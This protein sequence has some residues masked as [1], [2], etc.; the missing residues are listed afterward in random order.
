MK[1]SIYRTQKSAD[2]FLQ[3][4]DQVNTRK[5]MVYA[6]PAMQKKNDTEYCLINLHPDV[7]FQKVE[8][9]GGAIT[10]AAACA[11]SQLGEENRKK[12]VKMYFDPEEGIGYT[13][14]R[15]CMGSSD[16]AIDEYTYVE[17]GDMDLH[18]FD[19]SREDKYVVPLVKEAQ[20]LAPQLRFFFAP[21][22]PPLYMKDTD[23][24]QGG[25][26]KEECY[27]LYAQY[28]KK[29]ILEMKKRGIDI[30]LATVQNETRHM[31]T[32]ESCCYS[33]EQEKK[34]I[35]DHLGPVLDELGIKIM[36]Y[37]HCKER[38]FERCKAMYEDPETAK[39]IYGIACHWY[40]GDH[41]GE[42]S[43]AR[44]KYPDKG[45]FMTECCTAD[46]DVGLKITNDQIDAEKYA[47]ELLGDLNAG[48]NGYTDW[49]IALDEV[50]GP[51][52]NRSG[53]CAAPIICD[54]V[55]DQILCQTSYYYIGHFSKFIRPGAER[56]GISS[57]TDKLEITSFI[58]ED[59]KLAT[60]VLNRTENEIPYILR[61]GGQLL[62]RVIPAHTIETVILEAE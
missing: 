41:F 28:F 54:K 21:W 9:I 19:L 55:N 25:H 12:F 33:P 30:W 60:V 53:N 2:Q 45:I 32:W 49:N 38:V 42:L 5:E 56:I 61:T 24:V 39:Y 6:D 29:Y 52:H 59:G 62:D 7:T 40:S 10:E 51:Y 36:F 48:L 18:T 15:F 13:L 23:A 4:I 43:L 11:W 34:F 57:Y 1:A 17:E 22:T 27:D 31:Q 58:N 46:S 47:H 35:T 44:H 37:D 50:N 26:L 3:L 14:A 8:G 16:F 20:K